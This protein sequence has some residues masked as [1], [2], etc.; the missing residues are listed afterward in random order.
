MWSEIGS[1]L[2]EVKNP[3]GERNGGQLNTTLSHPYLFSFSSSLSFSLGLLLL[4]IS[5]MFVLALLGMSRTGSN[6][7]CFEN[8]KKT[9]DIP[10]R[11]D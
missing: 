8:P 7:G 10:L 4:S 6:A 9:E 11:S 3:L 2:E 1:R 5:M